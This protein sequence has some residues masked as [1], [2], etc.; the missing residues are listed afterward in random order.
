MDESIKINRNPWKSI[1]NDENSKKYV[2]YGTS[3]HGLVVE[4][5]TWRTTYPPANKGN[6]VAVVSGSPVAIHAHTSAQ[7]QVAENIA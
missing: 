4:G 7:A 6:I 5:G 3:G 1:K 2:S